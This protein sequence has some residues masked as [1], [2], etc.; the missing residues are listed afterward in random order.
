MSR[1]DT[2]V[3]LKGSLVHHPPHAAMCICSPLL[4]PTLLMN[5]SQTALD[6]AVLAWTGVRWSK[7]RLSGEH[8][9]CAPATFRVVML[10]ICNRLLHVVLLLQ[11]AL[12]RCGCRIECH[13]KL[14]VPSSTTA[15]ALTKGCASCIGHQYI[16]HAI[17]KWMNGW[18][19]QDSLRKWWI[20][21]TEM[22]GFH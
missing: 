14:S 8:V 22:E 17:W 16:S 4:L 21:F 19:L 1:F 6:W 20:C 13:M 12:L 18:L 3:V 10:H 9:T 7:V 11:H 5:G 15:T 2:F